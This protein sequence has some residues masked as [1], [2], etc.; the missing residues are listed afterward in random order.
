MESLIIQLGVKPGR[1]AELL[2]SKN[3]EITVGRS[4]EN[5]AVLQDPYIAPKLLR[6]YRANKTAQDESDAVNEVWRADI[7]DHTN[8]VLLNGEPVLSD[9]VIV[10]DSDR[11][12]VG[13]TVLTII[14]PQRPVETTR[15]LILSAWLHSTSI[16]FLIPCVALIIACLLDGFFDYIQLSADLKWKQYAYASLILALAIILWA[17]LWAIAGHIFR[18]QY[19]F[20]QQLLVTSLVY[21]LVVLLTPLP[22]YVEFA[23][24]SMGVGQWTNYAVTL[25]GVGLLLKFNLFLATNIKRTSMIA[26]ITSVGILAFAYGSTQF[27]KEDFSTSPAYS[28]VLKAPF[29]P[30]FAERTAEQYWLA[31]EERFDDL[32][33]ELEK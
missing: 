29:T 21:I 25:L 23:F 14:D 4:Y 13:R 20:R 19:H 16:G 11:L 26:M 3:N 8:P 5:D 17:G 9:S 27:L 10:K 30:R 1:F 2:R 6:I 18:S 7:L 31:V 28:G 33:K 15:K 12:T 22:A 24:A 32:D